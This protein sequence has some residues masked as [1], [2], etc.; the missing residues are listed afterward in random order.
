MFSKVLRK[1]GCF[2]LVTT[3]ATTAMFAGDEHKNKGKWVTGDFHNHTFLTDGSHTESDVVGHAFGV[4][5]LDWMANSE[6]GGVY[7]RDQ[8]GNPIAPTARW[9][10]LLENSFPVIEGLRSTY[11]HNLLIQGFEWNIPTHEHSSLGIVVPDE[12]NALNV[13]KFE[14]MFDQA[15]NLVSTDSRVSGLPKVNKTHSDAVTAVQWLQ[16]NFPK[17]SYVM[18]N[19]PS[20][21]QAYTIA[22]I[23]DMNNAAPD[24]FFGMEGLPGHQKESFRGGYSSNFKDS[25]GNDITYRARTWGGA[26]YMTAKVGGL[27]DAL[28]GEGR[29]FWIFINS[30]FHSSAANADFWPGEYAKSYTY[31]KDEEHGNPYKAV[32]DGMRSGNSFAVHGDLINALDFS[33]KS[34]GDEATMGETLKIEKGDHAQLVIRFQSPSVNNNNDAVNVDHIDLIAGNV[35]GYTV[36]GTDAYKNETNP[37]T[38]IIATFTAKDWKYEHGWYEVKYNVKHFNGSM[39][40]RIRGSNHAG[41]PQVSS[42][43]VGDNTAANAYADLWF[44]SNPIFVS[45][46]NR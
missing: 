12:D 14:Y 22:D 2:L 11:K 43:T 42:S 3:L 30:D 29:K 23:R 8:F 25:N 6:H 27:W 15:D 36:P 33:I 19:H 20:R 32:V 4:Y 46:R 44:Y 7:N 24:V 9:Q 10:T 16:K 31:V 28:L 18:L 45:V 35:T 41:D 21:K 34:E 13:A 38:K 40:F 5:K 1:L 39:Y 26:D 17:T 37:T